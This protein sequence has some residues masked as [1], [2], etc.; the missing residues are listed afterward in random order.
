[1]PVEPCLGKPVGSITMVGMGKS[2]VGSVDD[3]K[4]FGLTNV[5]VDEGGVRQ[6]NQLVHVSMDH[7]AVTH[8]LKNG[9]QVMVPQILV[10]FF[11]HLGQT[12]AL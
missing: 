3:L 9:N 8:L 7:Q 1:M 10:E 11:A 6:G 12:F 2:V 4:P 5:L